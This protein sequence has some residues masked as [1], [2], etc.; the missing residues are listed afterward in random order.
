M[1]FHLFFCNTTFYFLTLLF[2]F[3]FHKS[4]KRINN[5]SQQKPFMNCFQLIKAHS[6]AFNDFIFPVIRSKED[7]RFISRNVCSCLF[8]A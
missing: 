8:K 7:G 5:F 4:K 6:D 3:E 2:I 1:Y